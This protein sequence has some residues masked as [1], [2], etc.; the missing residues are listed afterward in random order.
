MTTAWRS[1]LLNVRQIAAE[2]L[3]C[4][5]DHVWRLI[6]SGRLRTVR[7]GRLVRIQRADLENL[8]SRSQE[9][10][11]ETHEP[12]RDAAHPVMPLELADQFEP[13]GL[14]II[15]APTVETETIAPA[16]AASTS[17]RRSR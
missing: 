6:R 9:V 3:G 7:I 8:I 14:G 15:A 11:A 5:E 16:T 10:P 2:V 17:R 4:S 13:R 12:S 1:E